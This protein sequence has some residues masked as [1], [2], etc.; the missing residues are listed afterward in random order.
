MAALSTDA[1]RHGLQAA[2]AVGDEPPMPTGSGYAL[3]TE[4][5][6]DNEEL[7]RPTEAME[8]VLRADNVEYY[9]ERRY[10][11]RPPPAALPRDEPLPSAPPERPW[12][13]AC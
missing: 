13:S 5:P 10:V 3:E 12:V 1:L 9:D 7:Q 2:S 6:V 8:Y 4:A 11:F